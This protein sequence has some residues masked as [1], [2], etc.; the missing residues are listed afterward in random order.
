MIWLLDTQ[1]IGKEY[2]MGRFLIDFDREFLNEMH[3]INKK[4][5]LNIREKIDD[6]KL[7]IKVSI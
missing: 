3:S 5:N 6:L 2:M 7:Y 1:N 4:L